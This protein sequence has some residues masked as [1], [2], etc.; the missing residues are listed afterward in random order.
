MKM[1][2]KGWLC[3]L[4][5][6]AVLL[7]YPAL[8][9]YAEGENSQPPVITEDIIEQQLQSDQIG[10]IGNQLEKYAEK[11][12]EEIIP[13]FDPTSIINDAAK[14]KFD[15]SLT[16]L[17]DGILKYLLKEFYHNFHILVKLVIIIALC[18]VLKNLQTSF[19]SESVGEFAFYACYVAVVSVLVLCLNTALTLGRSIIDDVV[20]FMYA[21]VPV[22]MTLLISG[23]SATAAGIFEPLL[24]TAVQISATLIKNVFMPMVFLSAV[25]SVVDN[26][27]EKVQISKL[28]QFLRQATG[29]TLGLILT[30]FIA[31]VSAQGSMGAVVDGVTSKTTKFT[32]NAVIPVA[33]KYLADAA[34]AVIGCALLIKNAA[35]L[36]VMIGIISICI[37]PLLKIF[38]LIVLFRITCILVEPI[39]DKRITGCINEMANSMTYIFGIAAAV[40]FMFLLTLTAIV[41]AGNISAMIR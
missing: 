22:L 6:A 17:I 9:V 12:I 35:G 28:S 39:S 41:G 13:G 8:S 1:I 27:S 31:V 25:L 20:G 37:L 32:I 2:Y 36:A 11:G 19:L 23:G 5:M 33:G 34:D 18:A 24:V 29:W 7:S 15:F 10:E 40:I 26:I 3:L 16:A 30:A 4:I 21:T 14:G 38:S